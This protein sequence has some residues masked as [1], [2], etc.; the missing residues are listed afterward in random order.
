M[1]GRREGGRTVDLDEGGKSHNVV[2]R[3]MMISTSESISNH[4]SLP[5]KTTNRIS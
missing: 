4:S 2:L 1:V 5:N 3:I